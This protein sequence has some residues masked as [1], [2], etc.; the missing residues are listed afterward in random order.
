VTATM[1][2]RLFVATATIDAAWDG[3]TFA[4]EE[5]RFALDGVRFAVMQSPQRRRDSGSGALWLPDPDAFP[6]EVVPRSRGHHGMLLAAK[7]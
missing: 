5:F 4:R 2:T 6:A 7:A 1:L 3:R